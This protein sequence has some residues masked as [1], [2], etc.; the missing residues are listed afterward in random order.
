MSP[1]KEEATMIRIQAILFSAALMLTGSL[2]CRAET[3]GKPIAITN[4][5]IFDG[6]KVIPNG[7]V[8]LE[9]RTITA[10]GPKVTVPPGAEVIDGTGATVLPGFVDAHTHTWGDA[11]A[12]AAV[13]GVT[14]QLDMFTDPTFARSMREEQGK[15]GAPGRADLLSAGFLATAPGGHGTQFGLPVPTLTQPE[16]AQAWVDA[17]VAE[18]SDYIKIVSEDSKIYGRE[19]PALNR[20]TIQA[21]VEAAHRRGKL[22]VVHISTLRT[23]KEALEAGADGLVHIFTDQAPDQEFIDLG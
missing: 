2:A 17:R 8:V 9:G 10:A 23:A 20:A 13:F 4:V 19:I 3:P 12:R 22:A 7:T 21:L 5:R 14:T 11:L 1:V 16:E 15:T 18:G 6:S